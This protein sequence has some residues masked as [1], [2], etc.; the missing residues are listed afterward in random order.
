LVITRATMK[1]IL[2]IFFALAT[3]QALDWESLLP[4]YPNPEFNYTRIVLPGICPNV[5]AVS[6]LNLPQVTGHY[7]RVL[8]NEKFADCDDNAC[9]TMYSAALGGPTIQYSTCCRSAADPSVA[10]CGVSVG[11]GSVVATSTPGLFT[12]VNGNEE[13]PVVVLDTDY[14][15]YT[16]I[17]GCKPKGLFERNEL[18]YVFA[19]NT[20]LDPFKTARAVDVFARNGISPMSLYAPE[21][22]RKCV[23]NPIPQP[24]FFPEV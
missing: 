4:P 16:I 11:S 22:G 9:Q 15:S 5:Q 24:C 13:W 1:S 3:V 6:N 12:Y 21:Q 2:V 7:F 23:Y 19:R 18:L 8:T 10:T 17:Y 20:V 14:S